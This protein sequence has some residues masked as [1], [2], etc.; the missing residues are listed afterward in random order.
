VWNLSEVELAFHDSLQI[1]TPFD[2]LLRIFSKKY[3]GTRCDV[4]LVGGGLS[5]AQVYRLRLTSSET[6]KDR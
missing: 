4:R 1:I 6:W 5:N 2:R 3:G